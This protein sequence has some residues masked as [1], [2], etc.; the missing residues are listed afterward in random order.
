MSS[1]VGK[2]I[3]E[4]FIDSLKLNIF[5]RLQT[6]NY[7]LDM[8]ITGCIFGLISALTNVALKARS[9]N[10][11]F[12][13][14]LYEEYILK[15]K[16]I[17]IEGRR[18][19]K[20]GAYSTRSDQLFSNRFRAL[21]Y[22]I[23]EK[24]LV[25]NSIYS[26]KEYAESVNSHDQFGSKN[27]QKEHMK[28]IKDI[29][30]VKQNRSFLL[31]EDIYCKVIF[32]D[33]ELENGS[34][35]ICKIETIS[36]YIYSYKKSLCEVREFV[37]DVTT[38]FMVNIETCRWNKYFIYTLVG[39]QM[40]D[41]K[42]SFSAW[43]ECP[44]QSHRT[45]DNLFFEHKEELI[46]KLQFFEENKEWYEKEGHPHTFGLALYGP[47][48]TGKTSVIKC[49]ANMLKRHLIVIPLNKIKT[50]RDFSKYYFESQ[51]NNNRQNSIHFDDKI[52]VLDDIDCMSELVKSR[53]NNPGQFEQI[54]GKTIKPDLLLKVISETAKAVKSENDGEILKMIDN[55][56]DDAITLSFLLNVIDGIRETPGRI[57]IIT[58]N[59]YNH[60]DEALRRPGRIDFPLE[61]KNLSIKTICDM[62]QHYYGKQFPKE[63][64]SSLKDGAL[65]PAQVVN[66]R[67]QTDD[68]EKFIEML[69]GIKVS[70]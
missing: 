18:C 14:S 1:Q 63:C 38:Q 25:G 36:L 47:P 3:Q 68:S 8:L 10:F 41:D 54:N 34:K 23:G 5:A 35:M 43:D 32:D 66:I 65:S 26:I 16:S 70:L 44:F 4:S 64:L 37:E 39:S 13:L 67:L 17:T 57:L 56:D 11:G 29:Y 58:S 6:G 46:K 21:W 31:G 20:S 15:K 33:E 19:I 49:I 22:Y 28:Y 52:I 9:F 40:D 45:F 27:S 53:D 60:I 48:G 12:M 51:Y 55:K 30:V 62:Y 59:Y 61:M 50:Q 69:M 2:N 42:H 7:I 24:L